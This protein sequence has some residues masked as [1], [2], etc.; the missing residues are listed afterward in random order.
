M[1]MEKRD[2]NWRKLTTY[3]L[4][5]IIWNKLRKPIKIETAENDTIRVECDWD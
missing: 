5:K 4:E 1:E 2:W 3:I